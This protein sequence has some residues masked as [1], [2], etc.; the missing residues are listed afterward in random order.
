MQK[1][2]SFLTALACL[3]LTGCIKFTGP[4]DPNYAP[5][6]P[7]HIPVRTPDQGSIYFQSEGISLYQDIKARKVG[8]IITVLLKETTNAT[9]TANSNYEKKTQET[10][11]EPTIFGSNS[12]N[13]GPNEAKWKFPKQ[14]PIPLQTT[15]NLGFGTT[16]NGDTKF[17]GTGNATQQ[18]QLIGTI[19]VVVTKVY[20]NGNL[21]VRGEKWVTINEGDEYVRLAGIIR[22]E[23]IGPDNQ[24]ESNRIADA[25]IT[26]SG[27]GSFAN[28]SKPGWLMQILTS[29]WWPL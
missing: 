2:A 1:I 22:N 6:I 25:R 4:D 27:R 14:L 8:D 18:N 11:P 19:T 15:D 9:K 29:P 21:Y 26:Y 17:T 13:G 23:D 24:I 7:D 10:L 3:F 28:S 12:Y 20:P 5:V 16:I